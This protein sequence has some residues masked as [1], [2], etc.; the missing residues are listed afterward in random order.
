[1]IAG[2]AVK[3]A[4]NHFLSEQDYAYQFNYPHPM[5]IG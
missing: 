1:M 4:V 2:L 5:V 3:V